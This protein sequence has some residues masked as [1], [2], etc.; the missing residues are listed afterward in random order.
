MEASTYC[1]VDKN[2]QI[3]EARHISAASKL[4]IARS[5]SEWSDMVTWLIVLLEDLY[6]VGE[7]DETLG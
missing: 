4:S 1:V 2:M 5:E 6:E 7:S 3:T